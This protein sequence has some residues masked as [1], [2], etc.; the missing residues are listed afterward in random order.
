MKF[1]PLIRAPGEAFYTYRGRQATAGV[2][3][4]LKQAVLMPYAYKPLHQS[5]LATAFTNTLAYPDYDRLGFPHPVVPF[6]VNCYGS[7]VL[8]SRD[9]HRARL[10]GDVARAA[11]PDPPGPSAALCMDIGAKLAHIIDAGPYRVVLMVSSS[12][13]HA[14]LATNTARMVPDHAADRRL[15]DAF[16]RGDWAYW[17]SRTTEEFEAAGPHEILN[18]M[19]LAGAMEAQ[20]RTPVIDDYAETYLFQANKIFASFPARE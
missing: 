3:A 6:H 5:V 19:L 4:V 15:L 7:D 13:S 18:W 11:I 9:S 2:G 20:G 17:R 10:L 12:W 8:N 14:A 16:K 1:G